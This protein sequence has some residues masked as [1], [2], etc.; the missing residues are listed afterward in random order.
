V[1]GIS[2]KAF[3]RGRLSKCQFPNGAIFLA[4]RLKYTWEVAAW[5]I[6]QLGSFPLG[7]YSWEVAA[8]EKA[9]GKVPNILID[10]AFHRQ[11]IVS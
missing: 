11:R 5:E 1:L 4:L 3:S 9:F 6:A 7:K 8:W 10:S 2:S